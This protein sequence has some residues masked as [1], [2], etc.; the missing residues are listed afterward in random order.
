MPPNDALHIVSLIRFVRIIFFAPGLPQN[1]ALF[2]AQLHVI[3]HPYARH[4]VARTVLAVGIALENDRSAALSAH[5]VY[6]ALYS[7]GIVGIGVSLRAVFAR[8]DR[9][10]GQFERIRIL[11][12]IPPIF[13]RKHSIYFYGIHRGDK[14]RTEHRDFSVVIRER[15]SKAVAG[16][17]CRAQFFRIFDFL[18]HVVD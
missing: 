9:A 13:D 7:R 6:G 2:D 8:L 18:I 15:K 10:F 1:R 14:M 4:D 16:R 5:G 3:L 17:D 11:G 12:H